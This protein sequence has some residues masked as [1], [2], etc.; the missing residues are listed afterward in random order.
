[1]KLP[2]NASRAAKE[3]SQEKGKVSP[4]APKIISEPK[5]TTP[6]KFQRVK[7]ILKETAELVPKAITKALK[8]DTS[9][10][11]PDTSPPISKQPSPKQSFSK[12]G[13]KKVVVLS[14]IKVVQKEIESDEEEELSTE[15]SQALRRSERATR[16]RRFSGQYAERNPRNP[17]GYA[18]QPKK[19]IKK[20]VKKKHD[21]SE[22]D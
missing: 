20:A 9:D 22:S 12:G 17:I 3:I 8:S 2:N 19:G 14:C 21:S 4:S 11:S 10:T 16:Q 13:D 1:V 6:S 7:R 5:T 15:Q 18:R